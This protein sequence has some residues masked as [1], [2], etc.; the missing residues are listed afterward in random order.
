MSAGAYI[1]KGVNQANID[2]AKERVFSSDESIF[3]VIRGTARKIERRHG[4]EYDTAKG[5]LLFIT[6]KRTLFYHAG[7]FGR[8]DQLVYPYD[9]ISSVNC[10]KGIIGDELQLQVASDNVTIHGIP[11][12]DGDIAAQNIRDLIATMKT[13]QT[14]V[15]AAPQMD[16][17]DQI[18][19]L[20]KLK[21]KGLLTNEEFERKKSELLKRL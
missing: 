10:H 13:Q 8:Y 7:M 4:R 2:E 16:I 12:G 9:Q 14:V 5:G 19:K 1:G 17:A 6:S 11:K 15:A 18:E 21:E 3:C 20:A